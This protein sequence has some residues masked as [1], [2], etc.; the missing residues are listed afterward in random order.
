MKWMAW[1]TGAAM[2][3]MMSSAT[4]AG[5]EVE[6]LLQMLEQSRAQQKGLTFY[7]G[8]QQVPGVVLRVTEK[9]VVARNQSQGTVVLRLDRIDGVAGHVERVPGQ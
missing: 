4:Q 3:L 9:H 8:G 7:I 6:P 5:Q 1:L 2:T